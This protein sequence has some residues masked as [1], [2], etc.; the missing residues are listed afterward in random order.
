MDFANKGGVGCLTPDDTPPSHHLFRRPAEASPEPRQSIGPR[1]ARSSG[2]VKQAGQPRRQGA[3]NR[4]P[5]PRARLQISSRCSVPLLPIP[6]IGPLDMPKD[7]VRKRGSVHT[8]VVVTD[9]LTG[10]C[11]R[12]CSGPRCLGARNAAGALSPR[13]TALFPLG[14]GRSTAGYSWGNRAYGDLS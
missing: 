14:G 7:G 8:P 6:M 13:V 10:G 2:P 3:E 9:P 1:W 12:R 5:V 4:A 11:A